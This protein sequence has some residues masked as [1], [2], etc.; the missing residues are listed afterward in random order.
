MANQTLGYINVML[1][2]I[3]IC[4]VALAVTIYWV[5][6]SLISGTASLK[7]LIETVDYNVHTS[8][9]MIQRSI[10][11]INT[12]TQKASD[13]M[14]RIEA[15][16]TDAHQIGVDAR[17]SMSMI[18]STLVPTLVSLHAISAGLRKGLDTW[19]EGSPDGSYRKTEAAGEPESAGDSDS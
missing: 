18:E 8:V 19:R 1:T 14:E 9:D 5:A 6:K 3:A 2:V 15:I 10:T 13:Q 11:D 16:I 4:G 7:K 17:T 12:I